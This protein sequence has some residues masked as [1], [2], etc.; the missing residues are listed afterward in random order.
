MTPHVFAM[1]GHAP[2]L[3]RPP[4]GVHSPAMW[5]DFL[6]GQAEKPVRVLVVDDDAHVRRV[7][8]QDVMGDER[9]LVV[10]Q[11]ANFRDAKKTIRQCDFD[12]M[13]VDLNLG[14]GDGLE[15]LEVMKNFRPEAEAIV[16]SVMETDEQVLR[17]F[18]L[19]AT[20]YLVKDSWFG[21]Y[22]QA[23]LQVFNGGASITPNLARRLLQRLGKTSAAPD[24]ACALFAPL[25]EILSARE[26]EVLKMAA[27]GHTSTE[28][29]A[30]LQISTMTVN[31]HIKNI[32][33]KL[34][35]RSRAHAVHVALLRG[36]L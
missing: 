26:R 13:L 21:N 4:M 25:T 15:L 1:N 18:E 27:S 2:R 35:V 14:D 5:P 33:R 12:V 28:I 20:G 10:A 8:A 30:D 24:K 19:G 29:A 36:W 34:Q 11:A 7:I 17:A 32:Y 3:L 16:V 9:T 23:V 31:A 6:K 22:S